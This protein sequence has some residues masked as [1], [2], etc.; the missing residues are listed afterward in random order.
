[1]NQD[2]RPT[3]LPLRIIRAA[4]STQMGLVLI[5]LIVL[6]LCAASILRE[7]A[8]QQ[9]ESFTGRDADEVYRLWPLSALG[10]LLCLN[11]LLAT[12][13]R[14]PLDWAHAGAVC[15]HLG[16]IVLAIG[17]GTYVAWGVQ[18]ECLT[19]LGKGGWS[20]IQYF[21]INDSY[22][23]G[24]AREDASGQGG[25]REPEGGQTPLGRLA[26]ARGEVKLDRPVAGGGD[27]AITAAAFLAH[28]DFREEWLDD[29]PNEL[30]A[31][32][33]QLGQGDMSGRTVLSPYFADTTEFTGRGFAIYYR[34]GTSPDIL[35]RIA[36][37][38]SAPA[39]QARLEMIYVLTGPD[40]SPT[41]VLQRPD[42]TRWQHALTPG[43]GL[44]L[45]LSAQ[46]LHLELVKL[47]THARRVYH[48]TEA[49]RS[50]KEA[51][52]AVLLELAAGA[53]RAKT[54]V[55][56]SRFAEVQPPLRIDVPGGKCLHVS[57][58]R[59]GVRFPKPLYIVGQPAY[60]T[61]PG[62]VVPKDYRCDVRI[63]AG[64]DAPRETISLNHPIMD[65][66]FQVSQNTWLP[67][68]RRPMA[69]ILGVSS[70]P[71]LIT[72]WAGMAMI[73]IGL[74][75]AFYLKPLMLRRRGKAG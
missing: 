70:R 33:L 53:W 1:M 35:R 56:F 14:V 36:Q 64:A 54:W 11:I 7:L 46:P 63:G 62:S 42:G 25:N 55:P 20:E 9:L 47:Y 38:T 58:T 17:A 61:Y 52:P 29:S 44:A 16:V 57:F 49:P 27:V 37:P 43:E 71:G 74:P 31:V 50:D 23:L 13:F 18:G 19:R 32:A 22:A 69:I 66:Q 15:T 2:A 8:P 21:Y 39:S 51:Q 10:L 68:G 65:G 6:Y 28:A 45:P 24:V 30:P 59:Q 4:A 12:L 41:L 40:I 3:S 73:I 72:I 5:G 34:P 26:S 48:A 60:E 67:S 75:V